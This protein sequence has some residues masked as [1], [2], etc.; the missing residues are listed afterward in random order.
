MRL[1]SP[2]A[3]PPEVTA[4]MGAGG[5]GESQY[6]KMAAAL[7]ARMSGSPG[8]GSVADTARANPQGAMMTMAEGLKKLVNQMSQTN[9]G[10]APYGSRILEILDAGMSAALGGEGAGG[11]AQLTPPP[12]PPQQGE[13]PSGTFPG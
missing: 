1:D 11:G 4:Q 7:R 6:G 8:A 13:R 2:P 12:V 5:G 9:Q 10:F 3:Q